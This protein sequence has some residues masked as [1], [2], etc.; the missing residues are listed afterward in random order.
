VGAV[1]DPCCLPACL[2][3]TAVCIR[4]RRPSLARRDLHCTAA[5]CR[6]FFWTDL[7]MWPGQVPHHVPLLL[8]L[9]GCDELLHCDTVLHGLEAAKHPN[10]Q[11]SGCVRAWETACG[12]VGPCIAA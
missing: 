7:N 9:H 8:A 5:F 3:P 12:C 6:G 11:V 1:H 4:P 10:Q 2:L